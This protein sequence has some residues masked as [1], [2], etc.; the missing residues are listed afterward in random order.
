VK[1]EARIIG[2]DD[3]PFD[4]FKDTSTL[5]IATVFRGGD[6]LDA[7]LSTD[8]TIDGA[9]AT[10][11]LIKMI[12]KCK[13]KPQLRCI[14]LDGIA[15][16]GFNVINVTEL[17]KKTKLP[18]LITLRK[19]PNYEKIFKALKKLKMED[20]I[21]LIEEVRKPEKMGRIYVQ[22]IGL[23]KEQAKKILKIT[24]TRSFLPEPIRIAHIIGAGI[25]KGESYGRA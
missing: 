17:H 11:N 10:K 7:V 6:T 21:P 2:I 12:N 4:K 1:K 18:I 15:V 19:L 5:V 24:C 16:G 22:R 25:A 14:I 8:I 3:A 20:K 13:Y 9:D 23:T